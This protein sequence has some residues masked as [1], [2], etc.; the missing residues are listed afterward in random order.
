[1]EKSFMCHKAAIIGCRQ[2]HEHANDEVGAYLFPWL[3]GLCELEAPP[4]AVGEGSPSSFLARRRIFLRIEEYQWF[5]MA[6]S[7]LLREYGC[8]SVRMIFT[9][10]TTLGFLTLTA[11]GG[12]WQSRPTCSQV[13]AE[14]HE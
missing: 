2:C 11:Q 12:S 5:L 8:S 9:R 13:F 14:H 10:T 3:T 4:A 1:M 7:V 6:L